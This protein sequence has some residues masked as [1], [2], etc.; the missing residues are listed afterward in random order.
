VLGTHISA[1][2]GRG[3]AL[4]EVEAAIRKLAGTVRSIEEALPAVDSA[5]ERTLDVTFHL[6]GTI[7]RPDYEGLRT[8]RWLSKKRLLVVQIA[9]LG[10]LS[11]ASDVNNS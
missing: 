4:S 7:L 5:T 1:V 3:G 6:P 9:V 2:L 11:G 10:T 8:G